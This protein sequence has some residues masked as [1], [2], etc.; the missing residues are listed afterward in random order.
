MRPEKKA[1]DEFGNDEFGND[2]C[3]N[4]TESARAN[5]LARTEG[6]HPSTLKPGIVARGARRVPGNEVARSLR[7]RPT[8]RAHTRARDTPAQRIC[9]P[10]F[11]SRFENFLKIDSRDFKSFL[12]PSDINPAARVT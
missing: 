10:I 11:R 1:N 2:E 5:A 6:D 7:P 8:A 4:G 12:A 3:G 9:P